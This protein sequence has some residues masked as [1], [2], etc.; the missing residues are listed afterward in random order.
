MHESHY[1]AAAAQWMRKRWPKD[2]FIEETYTPYG[3]ESLNDRRGYPDI[4]RV[5]RNGDISIV[6]VK[7]WGHPDFQKWKI[8]G[9]LQFYTFLIE[10][11][12]KQDNKDYVWMANLITKGMLDQ[13]HVDAIEQR[14][15]EEKEI[16][17][18][19]LVLIIGGNRKQIEQYEC[20]WH[21]HDYINFGDETNSWFRPLNYI[22]LIEE[23]GEFICDNLECW[24]RKDEETE[25][26]GAGQ[27]R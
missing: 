5:A 2:I 22:H 25:P 16:V 10:T 24:F 1:R 20:L 21:M 19:W 7:K 15:R 27:R 8:L 23:N 18:D 6:E 4:L 13:T 3:T 12:Y 11:Q 14:I 17:V 9:E 26:D